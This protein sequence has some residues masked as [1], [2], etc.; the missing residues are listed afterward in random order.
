[1][2]VPFARKVK[3]KSRSMGY[4]PET[5]LGIEGD[6]SYREIMAAVQPLST[7]EATEFRAMDAGLSKSSLYKLYSMELLNENDV[8]LFSLGA[9]G[10]SA[11]I[12]SVMPYFSDGNS[13]EHYKYIAKGA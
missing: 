11:Q 10:V 3:V 13:C 5:G 9:L 8:V 4:D 7:S 2:S 6:A 1:M 12:I